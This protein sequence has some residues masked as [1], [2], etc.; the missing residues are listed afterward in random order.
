MAAYSC[1]SRILFGANA[2]AGLGKGNVGRRYDS[3]ACHP[4]LRDGGGDFGL[5]VRRFCWSGGSHK[6]QH[7]AEYDILSSH[8][9]A[10]CEGKAEETGHLLFK[11]WHN[12]FGMQRKNAP[13]LEAR[14]GIPDGGEKLPL[15]KISYFV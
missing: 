10:I 14:R 11:I 5:L 8:V 2:I 7:E 6:K 13:F 15:D 4:A 9:A 3:E 12:E 1:A